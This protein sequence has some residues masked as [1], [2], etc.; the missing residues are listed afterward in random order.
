MLIETFAMVGTVKKIDTVETDVIIE[1][2]TR[3][4]TVKEVESVVQ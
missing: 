3:F 4:E 1:I 2:F